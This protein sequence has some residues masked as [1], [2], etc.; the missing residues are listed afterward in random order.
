MAWATTSSLNEAKQLHAGCGTTSAALCFGG[1]TGGNVSSTEIWWVSVL[2]GVVCDKNGSFV[3]AA[4]N[5]DIYNKDSRNDRVG[6]AVSNPSDGSW[7]FDIDVN[8]GTK[9]LVLFSYEGDYGGD[10]DIAGAEYLLSE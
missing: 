2:S 9:Y 1:Y 6:T 7:S 5:V 4:C 8:V 3:N 10:T